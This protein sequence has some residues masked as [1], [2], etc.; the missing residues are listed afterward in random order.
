MK[1]IFF[2]KF[3]STP[4]HINT[5]YQHS[6]TL[7]T[8][9]IPPFVEN[10]HG[11]LHNLT[12]YFSSKGLYYLNKN[13]KQPKSSVTRHVWVR[14]TK[15][16]TILLA[17]GRERIR[18]YIPKAHFRIF[19]HRNSTLTTTHKKKKYQHFPS[20]ELKFIYLIDIKLFVIVPK[21]RP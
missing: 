20:F 17:Q 13:Q 10:I 5:K 8:K 7:Q 1:T 11:G 4:K 12:G 9:V 21:Q 15:I 16:H 14:T 2:K 19:Q 6:G 18:V 3:R